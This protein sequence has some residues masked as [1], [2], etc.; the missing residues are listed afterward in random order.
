MNPGRLYPIL[1]FVLTVGWSFL[2]VILSCGVGG[3]R[4]DVL[5][6]MASYLS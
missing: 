2:T 5:I 4:S 6:Q 3:G 1:E